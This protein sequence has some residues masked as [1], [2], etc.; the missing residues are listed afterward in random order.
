MPCKKYKGKQRKLCF[1]T[2]EW[3]NWDDIRSKL[4]Y[5]SNKK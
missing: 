4:G 1:S 2:N 5:K 3:K